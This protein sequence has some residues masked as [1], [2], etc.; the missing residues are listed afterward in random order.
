MMKK[1]CLRED[2]QQL[3]SVT[4][5]K[6]DQIAREDKM[7]VMEKEEEVEGRPSLTKKQGL[8]P[9]NSKQWVNG[10]I[11]SK[12]KEQNKKK[13]IS[14]R[15][16]KERKQKTKGRS[17][18]HQNEKMKIRN[19]KAKRIPIRNEDKKKDVRK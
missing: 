9:K 15:A 12:E 8:F 1:V 17:E 4:V 14:H 7:V 6:T 18:N 11:E 3:E 2:F 13:K 10:D 5:R 16:V 19:T